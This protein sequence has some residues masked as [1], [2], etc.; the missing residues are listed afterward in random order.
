[1]PWQE[2]DRHFRRHFTREGSARALTLCCPSTSTEM[3]RPVTQRSPGPPVLPPSASIPSAVPPPL[4]PRILHTLSYTFV[5]TLTTVLS[6]AST[7]PALD[8]VCFR[9]APPCPPVD[10]HPSRGDS[11]LLPTCLA[12]DACGAQPYQ[13]APDIPE[14][15]VRSIVDRRQH[16]Q[17]ERAEDGPTRRTRLT[18]VV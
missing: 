17:D 7:P 11:S 8:Y 13:V 6:P 15:R 4:L 2:S 12:R 18:R 16:R 1:M 5:Y 3:P 10:A 9:Y 14:L